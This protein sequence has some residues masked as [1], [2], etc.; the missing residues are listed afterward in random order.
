MTKHKWC[1]EI[2]A[3]AGGAEIEI[4]WGDGSW[5]EIDNPRWDSCMEYRIKPP[6]TSLL[7]ERDAYANGEQIQFKHKLDINP[8]SWRDCNT[9]PANWL[10][11]YEYRIKPQPKEPKYLYV[12]HNL[13]ECKYE[14]GAL[15]HPQMNYRPIIGK[16]E[17]LN[18]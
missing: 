5:N 13:D 8:N 1:N 17:V 15:P 4:K 16:I 9:H 7:K 10:D 2:V 6:Q 11:N 3:W 12:F 14:I 18:D